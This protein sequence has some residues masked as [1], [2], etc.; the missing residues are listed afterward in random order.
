MLLASDTRNVP[1]G[2]IWGAR[3]LQTHNA[4]FKGVVTFDCLLLSA[5]MNEIHWKNI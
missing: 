5:V 2:C 4:D 1:L 3:F